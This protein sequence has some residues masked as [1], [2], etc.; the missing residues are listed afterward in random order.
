MKEMETYLKDLNAQ[1]ARIKLERGLKITKAH[2]LEFIAE[3]VKGDINDK[4]FQ[5]K[6]IDRLVYKVFV[7]DGSF[8]VLVNFF[9]MNKTEHVSFEDMQK[10]MQDNGGAV[11]TSSPILHQT[12][13]IRTPLLRSS[14]FG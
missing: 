9:D 12:G 5:K 2:I 3:L 11:Q 13:T 1:K 7:S 10:I 4:D 8:F 14:G 6:I